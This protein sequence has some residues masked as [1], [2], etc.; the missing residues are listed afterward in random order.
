MSKLG[1][2]QPELADMMGRYIVKSKY[3]HNN[4][5]K[6][7]HY[8]NMLELKI[9]IASILL[10]IVKDKQKSMIPIAAYN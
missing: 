2:L 1:N 4:I 8:V 3:C 6:Y 10:K 7:C 5:A 9:Y